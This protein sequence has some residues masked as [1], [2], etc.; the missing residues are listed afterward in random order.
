MVNRLE[1]PVTIIP[2]SSDF[3]N[4]NTSSTTSTSLEDRLID[5]LTNNFF[6]KFINF[7]NDILNY[8]YLYFFGTPEEQL[9]KALSKNNFDNA[10]EILQE[11]DSLSI[12]TRGEDGKSALIFAIQSGIE[13]LIDE[14]FLF[15]GV[16]VNA[17]DNDSNTPLIY[18]ILNDDVNSIQKLLNSERLI[19]NKG[20]YTHKT[21]LN[22]AISGGHFKAALALL[23][24]SGSDINVKTKDNQSPLSL[25]I[26]RGNY[27]TVKK[28]LSFDHC[29]IDPTLF[30]GAPDEIKSLATE[31]LDQKMKERETNTQNL[32]D[33]F[34]TLKFTRVGRLLNK[35]NVDLNAKDANEE[36]LLHLFCTCK[37]KRT[38]DIF[39]NHVEAIDFKAKNSEDETV[40]H[41]LVQENNTENL[42]MIISK[43][44]E[45]HKEIDINATNKNG[46]TALGIASAMRSTAA[47]QELLRIDGIDTN[48]PDDCSPFLKSMLTAM[49]YNTNPR[50]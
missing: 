18:A 7:V 50:K 32:L 35:G 23:E 9:L 28:L 20:I 27:E 1:T 36:P 17:L 5:P 2:P 49:K 14:V 48:V 38:F 37:N 6:D 25:A 13:E 34:Q 4:L 31:K 39:L 10:L 45:T 15:K 41:R 33:A 3:T 47:I 26:Q 24:F 29:D 12:D 44:I 16:D 40:F 22:F 42:N 21:A 19:I 30:E 46:L 11:E 43:V 8:L